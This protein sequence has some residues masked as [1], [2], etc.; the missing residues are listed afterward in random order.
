MAT[1]KPVRPG[2]DKRVFSNTADKTKR[3]NVRP[4][5]MRGGIRL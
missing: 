5:H 2:K 1:R 3:V 4:T